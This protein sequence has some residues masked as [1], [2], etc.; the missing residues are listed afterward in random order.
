[1]FFP[2]FCHVFAIFLHFGPFDQCFPILR[3]RRV[4]HSMPGHLDSRRQISS[5]SKIWGLLAAM[6][7][8]YLQ[9][10]AGVLRGNTIRGNTTRNSERKMALW[11]GL[12]E[13]LWK[14]SENLWKPLKTSQT[15]WKPLKPSLSEIL[16]E[17]LS[18]ADFPLRT[19]QSCCP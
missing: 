1:M 11:E 6:K 13:G 2:S 9:R 15:L 14:T 19:S 3:F 7:P 16:S 5:V 8:G 12:W 10:F 17:T 4:F 18:E